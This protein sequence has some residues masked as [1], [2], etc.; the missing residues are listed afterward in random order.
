MCVFRLHK[1]RFVELAQI[2]T[3]IVIA[4]FFAFTIDCSLFFVCKLVAFADAKFVVF[5]D[6]RHAAAAKLEWQLFA[7]K[8]E[9]EFVHVDAACR[10]F[11]VVFA[12]AHNSHSSRKRRRSR[13]G[14]QQFDLSLDSN[15]DGANN[16][17]NGFVVADTTRTI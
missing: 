3:E 5:A 8:A 11:D 9:L 15:V 7:Y 1:R 16:N 6:V 14:Q 12:T 13:S 2:P 4:G 10:R 17:N